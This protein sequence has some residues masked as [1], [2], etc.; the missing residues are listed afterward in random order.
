MYR[1]P[2]NC[3]CGNCDASWFQHGWH[4]KFALEEQKLEAFH[5]NRNSASISIAVPQ[6]AIGKLFGKRG[7][8]L[9]Q[10][11][12]ETHCK[13]HVDSSIDTSGLAKTLREVRIRSTAA[14]CEERESSSELC[15]CVV[16]TLCLEQGLQMSLEDLISAIQAEKE[17]EAQRK[18]KTQREAEQDQAIQQ[19]MVAVGDCFN[20][21]AI[22]DA[23]TQT[24]WHP[25]RAQER[26]FQEKHAAESR[27]QSAI[28]AKNLLDFCK[29]RNAARKPYEVQ[30]YDSMATESDDLAERDATSDASTASSEN[31]VCKSSKEVKMIQDVFVKIRRKCNELAQKDASLEKPAV[32]SRRA[33]DSYAEH[34]PRRSQRKRNFVK[35]PS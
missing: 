6:Q 1:P 3:G 35:M 23:L 27:A 19:V 13:I 28:Q 8:T 20:D 34:L 25:D 4:C 31:D 32:L 12:E 7:E 22:K 9:R 33:H 30:D 24:D 10:L 11:Q 2:S 17:I 14:T 18:V 26:L 16:Q 15:L 5:V 21:V 29:T